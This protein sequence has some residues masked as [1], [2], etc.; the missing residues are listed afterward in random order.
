MGPVFDSIR[1]PVRMLYRDRPSRSVATPRAG[2]RPMPT[3]KP[4]VPYLAAPWQRQPRPE[5]HQD[6]QW[7][8][9][10]GWASP[11]VASSRSISRRS[12]AV[13]SV[14]VTVNPV[15]TRT[16]GTLVDG[17]VLS[18]HVSSQ[19]AAA[20]HMTNI[21]RKNAEAPSVTATKISTKVSNR[22]RRE[23]PKAT[24]PRSRGWRC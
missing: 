1:S 12:R 24:T 8:P 11:N 16:L 2:V 7:R 6:S 3:E 13:G 20:L 9:S 19:K 22:H 10:F 18:I 21:S 15:V 4:V 14:N 5:R 23:H 17:G